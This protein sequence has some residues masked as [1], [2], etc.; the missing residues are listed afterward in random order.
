MG[1]EESDGFLEASGNLT[2]VRPKRAQE[3]QS[4][5]ED[6]ALGQ[7]GETDHEMP[8]E[9]GDSEDLGLDCESS[10]E[11][12]ADSPT[13]SPED[14]AERPKVRRQPKQP[15]QKEREEHECTHIPY[16]SWCSHCVRGRGRNTMHKS[17]KD[18]PEEEGE[19]AKVPRIT[20]DYFF[21]GDEKSKASKNPAMVMID[22]ETGNR[23]MRMVAHK[24]LDE[25]P[26]GEWIIK[27][28]HEE[29]KAWGH[30]GGGKNALVMKSDG[31]PAMV[32]VREALAAYHGGS[33]APEKPP[34]GESQSN[35]RVEEAGKTIRGIAKVLKD[36]IE[37]RTQMKIE[38]EHPVMQWMV[39]WA[40]MLHNR[41]QKGEDGRTAYQRQKGRTCQIEVV[42]FGEKVLYKKLKKEEERKRAVE[43]D[44][45]TGV[46][47]G[48]SRASSEVLIGTK[49]GVVRAWAVKRLPE[50]EQWCAQA[51]T[52]MKGTPQRPDPTKPGTYIPIRV[53]IEV[54]G[55]VPVM[56]EMRPARNDD[57]P[58]GVY[59][60]R[61]DFEEHEYTE[62][63][64]GC[65]RIKS[66]LQPRGH[67]KNCRQRMTE[68]LKKEN[69]PRWRAAKE[70]EDDFLSEPRGRDPGGEVE[71]PAA[72]A[73]RKDE[74]P[75]RHQE[76]GSSGSGQNQP[77]DPT[78][79]V[80]EEQT[81][82][83]DAKKARVGD[84]PMDTEIVKALLRVDVA[85]V[86]S[87][88]RV[89]GY[90][91]EYG[92]KPGKAMDLTT[93]WDFR[94]KDHRDM[95]LQ[96]VRED[97]PW[98]LIGS[99][100]CTMFSALQNLSEWNEEKQKKWG[101]AREHIR[102]VVQLYKIQMQAGRVF[103]HE[104]PARASSWDLEEIKSLTI[105]EEVYTTIADQCMYGLMTWTPGRKGVAPA[106]KPT[107][108][109]TNSWAM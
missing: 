22:E 68:I 38:A 39:R 91:K 65:R 59:F 4:P 3:S 33:I 2:A 21:L 61:K 85:E 49:D 95:A 54:D 16:R 80:E 70:R 17:V 60:K 34:K 74:G 32:A 98:L 64:E 52:D 23:Y 93:G 6:R 69:N 103:L 15:S 35:G 92:L 77:T 76:G 24:G 20:M 26:E 1:E 31:E 50:G 18:S 78:V 43:S 46:W 94:R 25:G 19:S 86:Y 5:M 27:D 73:P 30:P 83:P 100:M 42:P 66:G 107:K 71:E 108:F 47:L 109:M 82:E 84:S 7:D 99:P 79:K 48:H 96:Y 28:M 37:R 63:C 101:E 57:V 72:K 67:N 62:G 51:L 53:E 104:H 88:V 12:T 75:P 81:V 40:A 10:E 102:F 36:Q 41:Y 105:E 8:E 44:W 9:K 45:E 56:P 58:K 11:Q 13:G 97:K 14:E 55:P 89:T 106:K 90:A 87:P 29:L